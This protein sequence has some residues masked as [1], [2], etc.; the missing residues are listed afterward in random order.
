MVSALV[1]L[2]EGK[3][4]PMLEWLALPRA[5]RGTVG[6]GGSQPGSPFSLQEWAQ[7][8]SPRRWRGWTS[9]IDIRP[10][11]RGSQTTHTNPR[12][13]DSGAPRESG[14]SSPVSM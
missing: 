12:L 11:R 10:A 14:K 6:Q 3:I 1:F 13:E 8:P 7:D 2:G 4:Q 9:G 5:R